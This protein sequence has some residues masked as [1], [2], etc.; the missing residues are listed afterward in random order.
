MR[1]IRVISYSDLTRSETLQY[2][3][4]IR[5]IN[6]RTAWYHLIESLKNLIRL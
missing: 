6:R 2:R 3:K 1:T 4:S 5:S